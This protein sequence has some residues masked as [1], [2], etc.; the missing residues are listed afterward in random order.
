MKQC[1]AAAA[2]PQLLPTAP[3]PRHIRGPLQLPTPIRHRAGTA[4]HRGP[5]STTHVSGLPVRRRM[6]LQQSLAK[7]TCPR[8]AT[9]T[10]LCRLSPSTSRPPR[11]NS[12]ALAK[13]SGRGAPLLAGGHP[14]D[15]HVPPHHISPLRLRIII[16]P[17]AIPPVFTLLQPPSSSASFHSFTSLSFT[18]TPSHFSLQSTCP[19]RPSPSRSH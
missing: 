17:H 4:G 3:G 9:V 14:S 5:T 12:A 18:V 6:A 8:G 10:L 16:P 1:P 7:A 13:S 11:R 2:G 15:H 19:R